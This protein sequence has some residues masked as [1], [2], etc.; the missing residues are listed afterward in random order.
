MKQQSGARR[1][2]E[3]LRTDGVRCVFG[4]PGTQTTELFEALRATGLRTVLATSEHG[5]AFMAGGWARVT[6]E[7][8]VV[9]TIGGPGFTWALT[10]IAE[11]RLDSIPLL[12]IAGSPPTQ[13]SGRRFRQQELAQAAIAQSLVKSVIDAGDAADPGDAAHAALR[14]AR[15]GEPGPVL[16]HVSQEALNRLV[17][18]P[19]LMTPQADDSD[20]DDARA[21]CDRLRMSRRPVFFVGQGALPESDGIREIA[22]KLG[23]PVITT[24]SARGLLSEDHP[25]NLG[26]DPFAGRIE[27][28]NAFLESADLVVVI[29]AKLGHNGTTGFK[30]RLDR[31]RLV[32]VDAS[33]EVIGANYPVSLGL[34]ADVGDALAPMRSANLPT[35]AWTADELGVWRRR[36]ACGEHEGEPRVGGTP[37]GDA[38]NFFESLR[39]ALPADAIVVL[40]SGTHQILARR[41]YKALCPGG[42]VFP[43]DLQS[44]GFAIPTAIGAKIAAPE[45]IVV[46][47]VGD[48]GFAMTGLELLSAVREGLSIIFI[49]FV[50]GALG[51]IRLQQLTDYGVTH[52]VKLANP[53][54]GLFAAAVGAQYELIG[55]NI[56]AAVREGIRRGGVTVLEVPVGDTL[57][58]IRTAITSRVRGAARRVIGRRLID[59]VKRLLNR[60]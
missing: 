16:L 7:P 15:S 42:I 14:C 12:H 10:G 27:E 52:A 20:R 47:I 9:V 23:A 59:R 25:L 56:E 48:G 8:G 11:A 1:I 28:L 34:V 26:F 4:L 45:R 38:R 2:V 24:P 17:T 40:D 13:P 43:S 58:I 21:I 19:D 18:V 57:E 53:D 55:E 22:E 36:I 29:G 50:D 39:R 30:L 37:S 31:D 60:G 46:A 5:A 32:H 41:Y 3:S 6:G 33:A 49:V 54:F 44:M 35:S 51:Q